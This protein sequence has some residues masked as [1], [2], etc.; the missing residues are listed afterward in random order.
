VLYAVLSIITTSVI[1]GAW[2]LRETLNLYHWLA[3]ASALVTIGFYSYGN[4]LR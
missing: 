2:M 3:V 1:V 4:S